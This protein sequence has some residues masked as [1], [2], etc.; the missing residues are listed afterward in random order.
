MKYPKLPNACSRYGA[1]MGR[2]NSIMERTAEIKFHLYLM[3]M[4]DGAYDTGGA[5]WGSGNWQ[6][7]YMYHAYGNGPEFVNEMF[8]RARDREDAKHQVRDAFKNAKFYR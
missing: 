6:I 4:V 1:S 8:V 2:Q 5:Y 7:G 3:P